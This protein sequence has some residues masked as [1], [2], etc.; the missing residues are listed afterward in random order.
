MQQEITRKK[1]QLGTIRKKHAP[2]GV[3]SIDGEPIAPVRSDIN[4]N[5]TTYE[6]LKGPKGVEEVEKVRE[7]VSDWFDNGQKGSLHFPVVSKQKRM[8]EGEKREVTTVQ[9]VVI[10][11]NVATKIVEKHWNGEVEPTSPEQPV[12]LFA[13]PLETERETLNDVDSLVVASV[14]AQL[15]AAEDRSP[16]EETPKQRVDKRFPQHLKAAFPEEAQKDLDGL[17][18]KVPLAA[19]QPKENLSDPDPPE[20]HLKTCH[21]NFQKSENTS[22]LELNSRVDPATGG[23][24]DVVL[25]AA[26]RGGEVSRTVWGE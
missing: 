20:R 7:Q 10:S 16:Q 22:R 8:L 5:E 18:C 11:N 4:L 3:V 12:D 21:P 14:M 26:K 25:L 9:D 17:V 15:Q 13:N 24:R 23:T 2:L 6:K 1:S 19:T